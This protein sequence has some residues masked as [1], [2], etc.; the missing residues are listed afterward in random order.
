M[1]GRFPTS[2][3]LVIQNRHFLIDCGEGTQMQLNKLSLSHHKIDHIMISHLHGDHYLGLMGL[4]FTMH[5]TGRVNPI[6]IYS[7]H[8]LAEIITE[9]LRHSRSDLNFRIHFYNLTEG[10][11][12]TIFE[13]DA[14]TVETIVLSH[15]L[16]CS[17]FI[18]REKPKQRRIDKEKLIK[19]MLLQH[20]AALK[21]GA[22]V[23]DEQGNLLYRNEDFTIPA[24]K[25]ISY[26]F[27]SDTAFNPP[28]AEQ[29]KDIDLL[30]HE[31]TFMESEKNKAIETFHSTAADAA[32]M[33]RLANVQR[34]IIGHFSARY[35]ELD[36]LLNE[37]TAI[38]PSTELAIESATF[39]LTS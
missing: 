19:G 17:G 14:L 39:D 22:D 2:Q 30:Y 4:L 34:L 24:R 16:R 12:E 18:F 27:C 11:T 20:I 28:M 33:A 26:A 36:G 13:D 38:F 31:A 10:K 6:H 5:L 32:R 23:H 25:S 21:S 29:L 9:H 3:H 7:F 15:K 1:Y 35:R 37:A 8:G